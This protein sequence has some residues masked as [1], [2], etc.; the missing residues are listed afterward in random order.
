M[1]RQPESRNIYDYMG[2][3]KT[4]QPAVPISPGFAQVAWTLLDPQGQV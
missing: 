1:N 3:E 4:V 2:A